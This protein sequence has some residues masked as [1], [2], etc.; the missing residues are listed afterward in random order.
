MSKKGVESYIQWISCSMPFAGKLGHGEVDE[1]HSVFF[2][3]FFLFFRRE[4]LRKL[5]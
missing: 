3:F 2:L 4:R 5:G 1:E